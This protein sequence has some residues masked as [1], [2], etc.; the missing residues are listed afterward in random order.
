MAEAEWVS[1][2][3]LAETVSNARHPPQLVMLSACSTANSDVLA[4]SEGDDIDC[5]DVARAL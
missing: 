3:L 5:A 1:A 2:N 4:L